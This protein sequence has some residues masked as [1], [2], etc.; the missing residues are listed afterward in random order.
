[1]FTKYFLSFVCLLLVAINFGYGQQKCQ[2][3]TIGTQQQAESKN[4]ANYF[5][6]PGDDFFHLCSNGKFNIQE[7]ENE[8]GITF[9]NEEGKTISDTDK[10]LVLSAIGKRYFHYEPSLLS[11]KTEDT[12]ANE[13]L[14]LLK[15]DGVWKLELAENTQLSPLVLGSESK[16]F[17]LSIGENGQLI[18]SDWHEDTGMIVI[19]SKGRLIGIDLEND[20]V[21]WFYPNRK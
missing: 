9:H 19:F 8:T 13:K 14:R 3:K 15:S 10:L 11:L 12:V 21:H 5:Q 6:P 16:P 7:F 20:Y 1:M 4:L 2:P 18:K 17:L